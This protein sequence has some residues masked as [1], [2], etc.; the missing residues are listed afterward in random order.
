MHLILAA[1][2]RR[3]CYLNGDQVAAFLE[4]TD[5]VAVVEG[6]PRW[7]APADL[8]SGLDKG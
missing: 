5:H 3:L 4:G 2:G 1:D 7:V 8:R 6:D